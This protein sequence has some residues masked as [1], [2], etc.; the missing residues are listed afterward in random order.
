MG[1]LYGSSLPVSGVPELQ[2][3]PAPVPNAQ[4]RRFPSSEDLVVKDVY[5]LE[6]G[7]PTPKSLILK[8]EKVILSGGF[9][10]VYV[11]QECNF[12]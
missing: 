2:A 1:C 7:K 12:C 3:T 4:R 11:F 5:F 6:I 9:K 10:I 8:S